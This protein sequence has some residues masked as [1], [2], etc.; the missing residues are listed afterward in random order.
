[1][2][3][4]WLPME[5]EEGEICEGRAKVDSVASK[6]FYFLKKEDREMNQT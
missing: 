5:K 6:T 2:L 4:L 3:V 1:M